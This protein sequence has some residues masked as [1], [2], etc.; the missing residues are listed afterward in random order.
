MRSGHRIHLPG[1]GNCLILF[2]AAETF[3][4]DLCVKEVRFRTVIE[5]NSDA[6]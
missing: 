1:R 5:S 6:I 2:I 4:G 3:Q